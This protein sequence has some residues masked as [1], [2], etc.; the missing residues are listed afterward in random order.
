[1]RRKRLVISTAIVV[2]LLLSPM[3][4]LPSRTQSPAPLPPVTEADG[5]MGTCYSFYDTTRIQQ[6]Y[7]AGSRW[8]RFDFRWNAIAEYGYGPHDQLLD[9]YASMNWPLDVVGILGA[10]PDDRASCS[11]AP[12]S[13]AALLRRLDDYPVRITAAW[14][15]ACPPV[16]LDLPW[17]DANNGWGQFVY[18]TVLHFKGR[19][20]V[21]EVW[22]E[23]D[24]PLFWQGTAAQYA[25]LLKVAYQAI[26]AADPQATVLFGG[27]AYWYNPQ[28]YKDVL[29]I[30]AA[31]PESEAYNG[32]FDVMSLHLYSNA[33][34]PYDV[35]R[36]VMAEVAARVGP[37]PLWLTEAGVPVWD[38]GGS[39]PN[40]SATMEE[41][42]SYTIEAYAGARAAGV[43]KFFFFRLHDD[44][45]SEHYGLTRDD[46]SIRP[47]Y[48]AYQVAA[49][50]L[51][52]ENQI[53]GPF[54]TS[55][56]RITFWGT[57]NGRVDLLWN[58]T[59]TPMTYSM[60]AVLPQATLVDRHGLTQTVEA[61][62]G[63]FHL[64]LLP[65]TNDLIGGPPLLLIQKDTVP[66]QTTAFEATLTVDGVR[67]R[68]AVADDA[69]G[70]WYEDIE[71]ASAP[72]G[73]WHTVASWSQTAGK[74]EIIIAP[75]SSAEQW[76]FRARARD[77]TGNYEP[78]P[79]SATA[80]LLIIPRRHVALAVTV[81]TQAGD[82]LTASLRWLDSA[83]VVLTETTGS[84][85]EVSQ[86]VAVPQD[87]SL[88]VRAEGYVTRRFDFA[89]EAT[90][91]PITYTFEAVMPAVAGRVFLPLAIRPGP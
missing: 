4:T 71:Q 88:I 33:E 87:F 54:G 23:P 20:R 55:L 28:F 38:D 42:A 69:S 90:A 62:N 64:D 43:D 14:W 51:R 68:W 50:Y 40:Y 19:V 7:D 53:T 10:A 47:S 70:Y 30:I 1:M 39:V 89:P 24:L 80:S 91:E 11:N 45:W 82:P 26:K 86:T 60:P 65:R 9:R 31:D 41:A 84:S 18:Q 74:D 56:H 16:N 22:N 46:Y 34:T 57:P 2:V 85:W 37:H 44:G 5:R 25:R 81:T 3:M 78:W 83:G 8:D 15:N 79:D 63:Y 13:E 58:R 35:S 36:T 21:W 52:G 6:A 66:P 72:D 73:P 76:Y 12:M 75:P 61:E 59:D 27:L 67:L 48:V 32:Y 17:Y 77:R 29:D 49:R